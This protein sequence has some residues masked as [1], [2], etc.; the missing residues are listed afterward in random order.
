MKIGKLMYGWFKYCE[1]VTKMHFDFER[2]QAY[3][4]FITCMVEVE[5]DLENAQARVRELELQAQILS[6][7]VLS[8]VE[9][10]GVG[11]GSGLFKCNHCKR[12]AERSEE[13]IPH[14]Q[15]C[16]IVMAR[17]IARW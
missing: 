9:K 10:V 6:A 3:E 15:D 12:M 1:V 17:R 7:G 5:I 11:M 8:S 13:F 14:E 4:N 2:Q 16:P